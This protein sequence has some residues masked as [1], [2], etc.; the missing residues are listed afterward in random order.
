MLKV[1]KHSI[2]LALFGIFF[3]NIYTNFVCPSD[4]VQQTINMFVTVTQCDKQNKSFLQWLSAT[5]NI[6]KTFNFFVACDRG[7]GK[8]AKSK[9]PFIFEFDHRYQIAWGYLIKCS[10]FYVQWPISNVNLTKNQGCFYIQWSK[11]YVYNK[12]YMYKY[13]KF[14]MYNILYKM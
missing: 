4:S 3:G 10:M 11:F 8:K 13:N 2:C 12:F 14:Y 9:H 6:E 7:I 1:Q 5:N